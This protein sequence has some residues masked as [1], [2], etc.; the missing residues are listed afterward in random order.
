MTS[1]YDWVMDDKDELVGW[2]K[3]AGPTVYLLGMAVCVGF[4]WSTGNVIGDVSCRFRLSYSP[5]NGAFGIWGV[6]FPWHFASIFFQF[7]TNLSPETFYAAK[8]ESNVLMAIAW[9]ASGIWTFFF[10]TAD[11]PDPAAGLGFAA[12]FLIV[13]ATSAFSAVF[14]EN[15]FGTNAS[16]AQI[17]I[18]SIPFSLLA[19][20]LVVAASI[21]VG[22][23]VKS[24]NFVNGTNSSTTEITAP[25]CQRDP[26]N[27]S[28]PL[29][30]P[31]EGWIDLLVP[32][33]LAL[34][35]SAATISQSDLV[36]ALPIIWAISFMRLDAV[37]VVSIAVLIVC[38]IVA[39]V[40]FFMTRT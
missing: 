18:V 35:I 19:S 33:V 38:T 36:L 5:R 39:W 27:P 15:G 2:Q 23:F 34:A 40:R 22:V 3:A 20:W 14:L 32:L 29:I 26:A 37:K 8:F 7:L 4:I 25:A 24:M 13:A 12:F 21:S 17:F 28:E 30:P 16:T 1:V 31:P 6:L 9:A 11:S 10:T